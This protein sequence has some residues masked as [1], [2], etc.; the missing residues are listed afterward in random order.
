[1]SVPLHEN[2]LRSDARPRIGELARMSTPAQDSRSRARP[3]NTPGG[4]ALLAPS[5]TSV[6]GSSH[7]CGSAFARSLAAAPI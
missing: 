4:R 1:M 3:K 7:P 2:P 5:P 6:R